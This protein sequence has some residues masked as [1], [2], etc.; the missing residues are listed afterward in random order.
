MVD[1]S[2][3]QHWGRTELV[4][5]LF[6]LISNPAFF[7]RYSADDL[8]AKENSFVLYSDPLRR[9]PNSFRGTTQSRWLNIPSPRTMRHM[10]RNLMKTPINCRKWTVSGSLNTDS[11]LSTT[12]KLL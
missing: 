3:D 8:G 2:S 5:V 10:L 1:F 9:V 7:L 11:E 6:V 12:E 4:H